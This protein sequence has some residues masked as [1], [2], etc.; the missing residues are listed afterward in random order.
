MSSH[1][2]G[3]VGST[4]ATA[5][6][7]ARLGDPDLAI[8]DVRPLHA[9]NGWRSNGDARGGHIPGAIAFPSAWLESVDDAEVIRLLESKDILPS[10][11]VVLY[12]D[13]GNVAA[14]G[15]RLAE[16]GHGPPRLRGASASGRPTRRCPSNDSRSTRRSSTPDGCANCSTADVRR[17]HPPGA[18]S[19]ST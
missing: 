5:E 7:R 8:V 9:F 16:L 2:S 4:I 15:S 10:R 19:S 18:S 6:L 12:G 1:V 17:R 11:D 14:V 13:P 3:P